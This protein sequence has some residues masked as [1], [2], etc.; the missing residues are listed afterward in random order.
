MK[1][2]SI[3]PCLPSEPTS[4]LDDLVLELVGSS[5]SLAAQLNPAVRQGLAELV[6]SMNC[7]YSNL[8]EGHNT[9]PRDIDRA[10]ADNYST[11]VDQRLLQKEAR[12]HIEVQQLIDSNQSPDSSVYSTEY[13]RWIHDAF[14][15]RIPSEHR[16]VTNP[17]NDQKVEII[18]GA[19]RDG[20]VQ[21]GRHIAPPADSLNH[22]LNRFESAYDGTQLSDIR[23]IIAIAAAHHRFLWIHPFFDGN[24][25]VGRLMSHAALKQNGLSDGLWSVSRGLARTADTYKAKLNAADQARKGDLDG[26]GALSESALTDFC[27]YF[28][29]TC[30]DQVTFMESLLQPGE[31]LRRIRLY[32]DDECAAGRL[33]KR[34]FSLLKEALVLGEFERSRAAEI[35][36]YQERKGRQILSAL[37]DKGLL[38]SSNKRAPVR[39]GFPL[40]VV[41]RWLPTLYPAG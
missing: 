31:L 27:H 12:A 26:R 24:G 2:S 29:S 4:E 39:L 35:T 15:Q 33:P 28:L 9:H 19:L 40:D 30:I 37:L 7:Y 5:R 3:E 13:M 21:I 32:C 8:I 25:R 11:D 16:F 41:E 14:Y 18:P 17:D 6:R 36:G 34:S 20:D 23:S 1:L 10:L 38:V 22:F